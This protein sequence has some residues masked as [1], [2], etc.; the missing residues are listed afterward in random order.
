MTISH[1]GHL[2]PLKNAASKASRHLCVTALSAVDTVKNCA[3]HLQCSTYTFTVQYIYIYSAVHV[4][5][6]CSTYTFIVQ[7]IYIYSAVNVKCRI[8]ADKYIYSKVYFQQN[9]SNI[10]CLQFKCFSFSLVKNKESNRKNH[11]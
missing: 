9:V 8:C 5:L 1:D 4:H 2:L 7:Y 3:L 11:K 10:I 6:Q